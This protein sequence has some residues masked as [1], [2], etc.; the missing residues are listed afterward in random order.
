MQKSRGGEETEG[1]KTE[2]KKRGNGSL[3]RPDGMANLL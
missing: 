3:A 1:N 2:D